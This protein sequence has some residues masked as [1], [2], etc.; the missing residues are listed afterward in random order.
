MENTQPTIKVSTGTIHALTLFTWAP[1]VLILLVP[2][3]NFVAGLY[4]LAGMVPAAIQQRR[5]KKL[6]AAILASI[7]VGLT[8]TVLGATYRGAVDPID[9][10]LMFYLFISGPAFAGLA[11][12]LVVSWPQKGGID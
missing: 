7:P 5:G 9:S 11:G 3:V 2:F 4:A 1:V 6:L 10:G 12:A 8:L